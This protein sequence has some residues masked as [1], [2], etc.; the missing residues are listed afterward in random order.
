LQSYGKTVKALIS[1]PQQNGAI[2]FE[3]ELFAG[4]YIKT[5]KTESPKKPI[6]RT[7]SGGHTL[8][9]SHVLTIIHTAAQYPQM[10]FFFSQVHSL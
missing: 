7:S 1:K 4:I 2:K 8:I 3:K 6:A 9:R 5:A 10:C